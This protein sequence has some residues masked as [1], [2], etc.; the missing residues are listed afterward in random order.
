MSGQGGMSQRIRVELPGSTPQLIAKLRQEN[1]DLD[2]HPARNT[3]AVWGVLGNL[4][5][6]I[7][8]IV[9]LF[10]LFRRSSNVPR[11]TW[12]GHELWQIPSPVPDGS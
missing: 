2:I 8:L 1:V 10:F 7:F 4:I 6:P 9:G 12:A 3:G 11:R 5:F